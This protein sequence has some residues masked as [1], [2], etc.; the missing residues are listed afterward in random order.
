M[1]KLIRKAFVMQLHAGNRAEYVR[2]HNPIW[3]ELHDVLKAHG[4]HDYSIHLHPETNPLFG[5]AE[6]E[7]EARWDAIAET[8]VCKR[9]WAHMKDLMQSHPDNSPVGINLEEVF[10]ME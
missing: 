8:D 5:Y 3:P 6:I 4:V 1:S 10:Y 7:D 2:R 9:W